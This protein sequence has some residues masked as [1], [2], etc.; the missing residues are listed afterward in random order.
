M[1]FYDE[2]ECR[3]LIASHSQI[4]KTILNSN[5]SVKFY[6]GFDPTA[7]S[8]TVGNLLPLIMIQ[9]F[10][11]AGHV[12]C[13]LIGDFTARIGDPTGRNLARSILP[14]ETVNRNSIALQTQI[15]KILKNALCSIVFNNL[16]YNDMS[17]IDFM[18]AVGN[19]Y[20]VNSILSLESVKSRLQSGGLTFSEMSYPLF[21]GYDF[22]K[23][24][25]LYNVS[26][27]IGGS[28]QWGN[29]CSGIQ[30][31]RQILNK[32][33]YGFTFPL[34]VKSDGEKFGK[35]MGGAIWLDGKKTSP[36]N[37]FQFWI[38]QSDDMAEKL[39]KMLSLK[40][41]MHFYYIHNLHR[42]DS[43]KR[44]LQY[45]LA[46]EMTEFVHGK[47]EADKCSKIS[48][49]IYYDSWDS[50][51]EQDFDL[52]YQCCG[53][54]EIDTENFSILD[55][56]VDSGLSSS[57]TISKKMIDSKGI[58][59][60]NIK[61]ESYCIK[62]PSTFHTKFAVLKRGKKNVKILKVK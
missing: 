15:I 31:C 41:M 20:T 28:D 32:D 60:N 27:Q 12:P 2:L 6:C 51:N 30:L 37:F 29:I 49:A 40:S 45:E 21:Q 54:I 56:L 55:I 62:L 13:I 59:I 7:D 39:Y 19:R 18:N 47:N 11:N 36:W 52:A 1:N 26:L 3:G 48:K 50:L 9:R 38:T 17:L 5:D 35:S 8:L 23:L 4:L 58:T 43:S 25:E 22:L 57:R 10:Y 24:N 33:V 42:E 34:I 53:G 46:Y 16:F 14:E 61:V 44:I